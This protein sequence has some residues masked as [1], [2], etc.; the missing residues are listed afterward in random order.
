MR[1]TVWLRVLAIAMFAAIGAQSRSAGQ[2]QPPQPIAE[3][4]GAGAY[5]PQPGIT[6]PVPVR[7]VEPQYTTTA[8]RQR[9]QGAV[10]LEAIVQADG[11]VGA[12]RILRSLDAVYGLDDEA[13]K[14]AKQWQ[15]QP[16]MESGRPVPVLVRL[17]LE[18]RLHGASEG[19]PPPIWIPDGPFLNGVA[20]LGQPNVTMPVLEHAV[21]PKYTPAAMNAQ[22]TG[23]VT[24]DM[25]V[26][27]D[28]KVVR[29]RVARPIEQLDGTKVSASEA[30]RWFA[31]GLNVAAIEAAMQWRFK[32]GLV[33]GQPANV[34]VTVTME[35]RLR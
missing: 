31:A 32:P 26:G 16:G 19:E 1:N 12:V 22:I 28:G 23:T 17:V 24:V 10:E 2:T 11:T 33:N 27:P 4:F 25:V 15:F 29:S 30:R 3:G 9:I 20:L 7:R 5:R 21:E 14:A 34:L 6:N 35:F 18:Y 8:L 13:I